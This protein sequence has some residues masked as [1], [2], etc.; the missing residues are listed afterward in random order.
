MD[1]VQRPVALITG[2][3]RGIGAATALAL[4]AR[5]YDVAITFH[6]KAARANEVVQAITSYGVR[7]LAIQC[8]ITKQDDIDRLFSTMKEWTNHIDLLVLNASGGLERNLLAADPDYP[9]HINRDAQL[10]TLNST[11]PTMPT[12]STII[13]VTSHWAHMYGKVQ[14]LPAYSTIAESKYAGEQ[15][16]RL[17][18]QELEERGIRLIIVTGDLIEGTITP[19]LLERAA[20]GMTKD[21]QQTVGH[22]PTATE[23][24]EAIAV[25]ATDLTLPSGSTVVIGGALESLPLL[26]PE[27]SSQLF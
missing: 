21:R 24:G 3:S 12:G 19:K 1:F 8:D 25:A 26:V 2:G 6:N 15:A 16:L 27:Q 7:G 18:Q 9:M 13:F 23:M 20:P 4:A 22:L 11:L 14:D 17:Q 5:N 10:A